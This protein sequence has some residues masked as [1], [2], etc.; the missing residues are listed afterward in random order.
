MTLTSNTRRRLLLSMLVNISVAP[1]L[2]A[3]TAPGRTVLYAAVGAELTQYDI[4]AGAA[5]IKQRSVT[6]PANVQEAWQ[7]PST[8]FLYVAWSNGGSSNA[9]S[10][11]VAPTGDQHGISA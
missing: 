9:P 10:G 8:N 6:L 1:I 11:G 5:L 7:H 4:D 2:V 3:Q